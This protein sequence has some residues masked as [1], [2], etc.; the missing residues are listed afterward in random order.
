MPN[1]LEDNGK[2]MFSHVASKDLHFG[3]KEHAAFIIN[4]LTK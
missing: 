1:S 3:E 2:S 4:Q